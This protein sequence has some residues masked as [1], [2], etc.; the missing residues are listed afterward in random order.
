MDAEDFVYMG[1]GGARVL[2]DVV[3]ARV[4][5]SVTSIPDNAFR[6]CNMLAEVELCEGSWKLVIGGCG[7]ECKAVCLAPTF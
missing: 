6:W 5:P 4:D 7:K 2:D 3:R 1:E